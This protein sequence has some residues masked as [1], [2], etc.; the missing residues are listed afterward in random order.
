MKVMFER[1]DCIGCSACTTVCPEF[2]SIDVDGKSRLKG[3]VQV[4]SK[5]GWYELEFSDKT[6]E[7]CI[8]KAEDICPVKVIHVHLTSTTRSNPGKEV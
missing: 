3:G 1:E 6:T 2:W 8:K 5:P 7:D 4:K